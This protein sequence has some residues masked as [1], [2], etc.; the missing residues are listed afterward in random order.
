MTQQQQQSTALEKARE[1][2]EWALPVVG[3]FADPSRFELLLPAL[4]VNSTLG[5]GHVPSISLV[6]VSPNVL[7]GE[8]FKV[9]SRQENGAWVDLFAYSKPA[10]SKMAG[11]AGIS[12]NTQRVDRGTNRDYCEVKAVGGMK[13]ESGQSIFRS[14]T[15]AFDMEDVA[16]EAW[17]NRVARNDKADAKKK[18]TEPQMKQD[19]AAEMTAF[20]KHL[21][22]RTE[23]GAIT[24]VIRELLGI[25]G[26]QT[27]EQ[28]A[29]PK[30]ILRVDF[31]PDASD[32]VVKR[33]LLE[34]ADAATMALYGIGLGERTKAPHGEAEVIHGDDPGPAALT[35]GSEAAAAAEPEVPA[36]DFTRRVFEGFD[37]VGLDLAERSRILTASGGDMRK[38]YDL[39]NELANSES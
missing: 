21:L 9:G 30:V 16:A 4:P 19:H 2:P 10:L 27:R 25:K 12:I 26:A 7:D 8:V 1:L 34:R 14:A 22:R 31:R 28:I 39:L 17:R 20:R 29:K 32:P 36:E 37:A 24:A 13:N 6:H 11:A 35:A 5:F 15:K 18:K 23:A 38:A 33:F 3:P